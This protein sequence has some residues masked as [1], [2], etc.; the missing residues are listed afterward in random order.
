MIAF[1]SGALRGRMES[2]RQH[3][4]LVL[5][6]TELTLGKGNA[7]RSAHRGVL[8]VDFHPAQSEKWC[9]ISAALAQFR[10]CYSSST[11][12]DASYGIRHAGHIKMLSRSGSPASSN[13]RPRATDRRPHL[14]Q[15]DRHHTYTVCWSLGQPQGIND[16]SRDKAATACAAVRDPGARG[17]PTS[18]ASAGEFTSVRDHRSAARRSS[19]RAYAACRGRGVTTATGGGTTSEWGSRAITAARTSSR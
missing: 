8:P 15:A 14:A 11:S 16:K 3:Y 4:R 18:R 1:I 12:N 13:A 7:P 5:I 17:K 2:R 10:R 6:T 9:C 19:R